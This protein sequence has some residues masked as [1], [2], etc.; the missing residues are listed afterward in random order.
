MAEPS[1][2]LAA[3]A[4]RIAKKPVLFSK[5]L[6]TPGTQLVTNCFNRFM[7]F[8]IPSKCSHTSCET[9]NC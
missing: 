7:I 9:N 6:S 8:R 4:G 3:P 5:L 1:P 2:S